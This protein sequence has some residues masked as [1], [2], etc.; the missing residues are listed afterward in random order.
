MKNEK[1]SDIAVSKPRNKINIP[2]LVG[3][4]VVV[5]AIVGVGLIVNGEITGRATTPTENIIANSCDADDTCEVN[6]LSGNAARLKQLDVDDIK[7]HSKFEEG[8]SYACI[9]KEGYIFESSFP[10]NEISDT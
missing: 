10:C 8:V 3:V 5:V 4:F 1:I 7:F 9:N 6:K 2:Y